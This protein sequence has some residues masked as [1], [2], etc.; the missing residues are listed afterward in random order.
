MLLEEMMEEE[1]AQGEAQG[2]ARGVLTILKT[3]GDIPGDIQERILNEKDL[4]LLDQWF[5]LALSVKN[6]DEFLKMMDA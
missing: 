2:M 6:V 5:S 4:K 3:H 1:R